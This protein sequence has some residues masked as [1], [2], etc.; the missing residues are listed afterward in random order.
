MFGQSLDKTLLHAV[1][2]NSCQRCSVSQTG[3]ATVC[4][5]WVY[6]HKSCCGRNSFTTLVML[7]ISGIHER[8]LFHQHFTRQE[9]EDAS[10]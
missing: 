8:G 9:N 5:V 2:I 10:T 1:L 7:V 6:A 4:D 3:L